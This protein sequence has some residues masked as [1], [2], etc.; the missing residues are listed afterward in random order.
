VNLGLDFETGATGARLA[1]GSYVVAQTEQ[2]NDIVWSEWA[3]DAE[4]GT[5][6]RNP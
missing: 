6:M 2:P 5:I 1:V 3:Y 4:T